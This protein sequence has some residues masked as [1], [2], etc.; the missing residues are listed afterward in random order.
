LE[1]EVFGGSVSFRL[2]KSKPVL[3][4]VVGVEMG[5]GVFLENEVFGGSES[6]R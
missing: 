6:F 5:V 2:E 1:N 3:D 4:V